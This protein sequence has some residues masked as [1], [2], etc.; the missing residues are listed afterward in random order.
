MV[1]YI[2]KQCLA[3][4]E[5]FQV[6]YHRRNNK[7]TCSKE[8]FKRLCTLVNLTGQYHLCDMCDKPIYLV[9]S[10]LNKHNF[11]SKEC[12]HK[13]RRDVES[14]GATLRGDTPR[15]KYY[16]KHWYRI[17]KSV[18]KSQDFS[19]FDCGI[20]EKEYG[21]SLS[22]H[23]IIPFVTF[24]SITEANKRENLVG[25]C[26]PCHRKRHSGEGHIIHL[27]KEDLGNNA[28]SGYGNVR[29][30]DREKAEQ[31]VELLLSTNHTLGEISKRTGVSRATVSRIYHGERWDSL[32]DTPP[33]KT[34][35]RG[36]A[37]YS[38]FSK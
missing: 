21:K 35:P 18:R 27:S 20:H 1:R 23:H 5:E 30:K 15:K 7:K 38:K 36:K 10:S 11:C 33:I 2:T 34:N 17:S 29:L 37:K 31:V 6:M 14:L 8:C 22:V 24:D 12:D 26:E 13:Y 32:Y 28:Y 25:L 4:N 19:C 9:K 16:G 3:C